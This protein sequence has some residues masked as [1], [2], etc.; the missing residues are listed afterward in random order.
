MVRKTKVH[1]RGGR[2]DALPFIRSVDALRKAIDEASAAIITCSHT[3]YMKRLR[4]YDHAR[5]GEIVK[6][7]PC[8]HRAA[9]RF[10][11]RELDKGVKDAKFDPREAIKLIKAEKPTKSGKS[12]VVK[13]GGFRK[14]CMD[15]AC[16]PP[17]KGY[18]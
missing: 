6:V 14:V 1:L 9:Q 7:I 10:V 2:L 5:D 18:K 17:C 11:K 16:P 15:A 12:K 3:D 13:V 4:F 8:G